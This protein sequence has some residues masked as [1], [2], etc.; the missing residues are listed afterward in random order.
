MAIAGLNARGLLEPNSM[1]CQVGGNESFKT[2]QRFVTLLDA[3]EHDPKKLQT[4]GR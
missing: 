4:F 2:L 3:L 1:D